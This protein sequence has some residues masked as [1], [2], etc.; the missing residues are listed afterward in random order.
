MP[1]FS[2]VASACMSTSTWSTERLSAWSA[3]SAS[4]NA[5]RPAFMN[6]LP[7]SET[8][9]SRTPSR[10]TTHQPWPGWLAR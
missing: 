1:T 4:E 6:R 8:T 9:P 5:W 7:D 2:L 10:E 3:A